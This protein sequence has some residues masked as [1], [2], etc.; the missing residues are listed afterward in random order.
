MLKAWKGK[1]GEKIEISRT[2]KASASANANGKLSERNY[3]ATAATFIAIR[4]VLASGSEG[5]TY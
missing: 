1:T 3:N 2:D 5:D 4:R